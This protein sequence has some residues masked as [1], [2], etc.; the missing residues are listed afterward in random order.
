MSVIEDICL[1][2]VTGVHGHMI[3]QYTTDNVHTL[4]DKVA[5]MTRYTIRIRLIQQTKTGHDIG[6]T[7]ILDG[8]CNRFDDT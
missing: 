4:L 2:H 6:N 8:L 7:I 1:E 5:I 3:T